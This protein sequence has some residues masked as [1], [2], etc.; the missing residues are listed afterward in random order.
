MEIPL[1]SDTEQKGADQILAV[2]RLESGVRGQNAHGAHAQVAAHGCRGRSR[3]TR[4]Q[5]Q[6]LP[7]NTLVC[8]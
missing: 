5:I 6:K 4:L 1:L 3:T 2:F 7:E 8:N